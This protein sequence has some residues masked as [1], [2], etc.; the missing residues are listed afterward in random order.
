MLSEGERQYIISGI[1]EDV[2]ADGRGC[3]HVRHFSLRTG[4]ASNTSGSALI[5]RVGRT[6]IV[7]MVTRVC[8]SL[9]GG[10][11]C[12]YWCEGGAWF[13]TPLYP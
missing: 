8:S 12:Y 2:R 1:K 4:V 7:S 10:D 6:C 9:L 11:Q 3:K 5:E 13:A